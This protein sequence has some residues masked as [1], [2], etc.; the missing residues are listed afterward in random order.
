MQKLVS[1]LHG[2]VHVRGSVLI[3]SFCH[4]SEDEL[5]ADDSDSEES[6]VEGISSDE[7]G[8]GQTSVTEDKPTLRLSGGFQWGVGVVKSGEDAAEKSS[9]SETEEKEVRK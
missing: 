9:E 7:N 6:E 3:Y 4:S 8:E 2:I 5:V 1:S